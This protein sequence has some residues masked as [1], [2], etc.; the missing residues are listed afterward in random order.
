MAD[1][2]IPEE[3]LLYRLSQKEGLNWFKNI[4]FLSSY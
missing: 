3:T 4:A 1:S 2:K